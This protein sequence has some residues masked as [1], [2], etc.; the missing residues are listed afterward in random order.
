MV[1]K[2]EEHEK[3]FSNSQSSLAK[4]LEKKDAISSKKT[5]AGDIK[6]SINLDSNSKTPKLP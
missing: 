3:R 6:N 4:N 2:K 5:T 1:S